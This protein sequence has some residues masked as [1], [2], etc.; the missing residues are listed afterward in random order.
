MPPVKLKLRLPQPFLWLGIVHTWLSAVTG[1]GGLLQGYLLR[2]KFTRQ[3]IIGTIA[4][5]MF[6]MSILKITGYIWVGF[7]YG[8]YLEMIAYATLAGF[9]GT[10]VGKR[11]L[12][13]V[14]DD[15]FRLVLRCILTL[16]ASRLFWVAC[17]LY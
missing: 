11:F 5:T 2:G 15:Q 10:W 13:F 17:T 14:T 12:G 4:G 16:M 8:P 7:D 1:L 6:W 9:L 3:A